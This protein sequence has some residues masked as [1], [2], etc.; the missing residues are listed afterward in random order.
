[1]RFFLRRAV[2]GEIREQISV[3]GWIFAGRKAGMERRLIDENSRYD[4]RHETAHVPPNCVCYFCLFVV[5]L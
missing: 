5:D 2:A 4:F 1:M 3:V